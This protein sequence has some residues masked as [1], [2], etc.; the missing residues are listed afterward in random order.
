MNDDH[1]F[2]AFSI[3]SI[4]KTKK[5]VKLIIKLFIALLHIDTKTN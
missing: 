4:L 2:S 1:K 3:L 5:Y